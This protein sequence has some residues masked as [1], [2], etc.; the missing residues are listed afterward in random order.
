M[1]SLAEFVM[2]GRFQALIVAIVGAG[3]ELFFWVSGAV[4]ALVTLRKGQSQGAMILIWALLPAAALAWLKFP[5]ALLSLLVCYTMA[6]ALR[7]SMSW[8]YTLILGAIAALLMATVLSVLF[9]G[10]LLSIIEVVKPVLEKLTDQPSQQQSWPEFI[11]AL[12][13]VD[14]A[15]SFAGGASLFAV[16][17]LA[18]GRYWQASLYNP[19]GFGEEFRAIRFTPAAALSMALAAAALIA[20]GSLLVWSWVVLLPL[21]VAGIALVHSLLYQPERSNAV[22]VVFYVVLIIVDPLKQLVCVLAIVDSIFDLRTRIAN[23]G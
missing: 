10:Y 11:T 2:R 14:L 20:S 5:S 6:C 13:P 21:L 22:M 17:S 16:L 4:I 18:L 12:G 7:A 23:K 3:T 1:K 19:G 15:G 9:D 8:Q